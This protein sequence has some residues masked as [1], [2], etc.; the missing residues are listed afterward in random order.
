MGSLAI[1]VLVFTTIDKMKYSIILLVCSYIAYVQAGA[2]VYVDDAEEHFR[3]RRSPQEDM[4]LGGHDLH[5]PTLLNLPTLKIFPCQP[6]PLT[7]KGDPK[8]ASDP[9]TP[10]SRLT[11]RPTSSGES[12]T[13]LDL[14]TEDR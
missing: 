12:V 7:A 4:Q 3:V 11:P 1:A 10:S 9:S 6:L 8:A 14:S 13:S 2:W 5:P